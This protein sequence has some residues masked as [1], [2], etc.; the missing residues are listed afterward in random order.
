[1]MLIKLPIQALLNKNYSSAV[2]YGWTLPISLLLL[3]WVTMITP[4]GLAKRPA[5]ISLGNFTLM[6]FMLSAS[7]QPLFCPPTVARYKLLAFHGLPAITSPLIKKAMINQ[8]STLPSTLPK[9]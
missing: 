9:G 4:S 2:F 6:G 8:H 7:Q 1:V 3:S 5:L